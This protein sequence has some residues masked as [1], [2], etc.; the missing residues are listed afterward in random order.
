MSDSAKTKKTIKEIIKNHGKISGILHGAGISNYALFQDMEK[1]SFDRCLAV[2]VGSLLDI[3]SLCDTENLK[4][5][6]LIS[7]VLAKTGMRM[8][9]DYTFANSWLDYLCL[10]LNK[11]NIPAKSIGYTVWNETG[12]GKKDNVIDY[13]KSVGVV[14]L[15]TNDGVE[16]YKNIIFS[17]SKISVVTGRLA[18]HLEAN[19]YPEYS[20]LSS[21]K[22]TRII[23]FIPKTEIV[24]QTKMSINQDVY[25]LD[26]VVN[27]A[28]VLPIVFILELLS[29]NAALIAGSRNLREIKNIKISSP[30]IFSDASPI[31]LR[32]FAAVSKNSDNL[33]VAVLRT[34]LE[35]FSQNVVTCE[36]YFDN[37]KCQSCSVVL[38]EITEKP[39]N[40]EK[41]I[42]KPVFH[43]KFF[44]H[45]KEVLSLKK[46][47]CVASW[48]RGEKR[49]LSFSDFNKSSTITPTL[50]DSMLQTALIM[51]NKLVLPV[52]IGKIEFFQQNI[53]SKG[54][55]I[56]D[57]K[58]IVL[59]TDS[60]RKLVEISGLKTK[61]IK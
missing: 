48:I 44:R 59:C 17:D 19:L 38:P 18:Q 4:F 45:I 12:M 28:V 7:S 27:G 24:T 36:F 1:S 14:P 15:S 52:S 16:A 10:L 8:Q 58:S 51:A 50:I 9:A 21:S 35:G 60:G 43:G 57:R 47:F 55:C 25:L 49:E 56:A 23:R 6:H 29:K 34:S 11:M 32:S 46:D 42:P 30:V 20:S 41:F 39:L 33:I 26:H 40:I 2:K 3:L 22:N 53:P 5:V 37:L 61:E 13:L 54:F 31:E